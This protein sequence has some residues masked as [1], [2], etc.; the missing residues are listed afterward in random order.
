MVN[1]KSARRMNGVSHT[2]LFLLT[3]LA[4]V[5]FLILIS[6]S[7][8]EDTQII[9]YGY[10]MFPRGF[11]MDA[12]GYILTNFSVIGR[13][14]GVTIA[15]T[16]I[17]TAA[18]LIITNLGAYML[19]QDDLPGVKVLMFLV[20]F[21]MLF[22]GGL[23]PTYYIYTQVFH[24][25]DTLW[26]LIVPNLLLNAFN[27]ILIRNYYRFSIPKAI[28]ESARIDGAGE[29]T[30]F[31]RI[32]FPLS[33]PITATVGLLTAIM[34]WNDWQNGLYYL[35][36]TEWYSIQ[37]V[38][39]VMSSQITFLSNGTDSTQGVNRDIP[40]TTIRMAIAV[41]AIAPILIAYPFFQKYFVKGITLGAVKE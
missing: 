16:V 10:S 29:F 41:V 22:S 18:S 32:V 40:T 11:S 36:G 27:I 1:S 17:G 34:F 33:L 20:V 35:T 19:S 21:T 6:S 14:Y 31:V 38:L 7:F 26:C 23:V 8:S 28:V 30:T 25:K 24:L 12:Y 5:P 2:V 3:F 37:Q 15:V 9:K 39:R 13:A 4:L